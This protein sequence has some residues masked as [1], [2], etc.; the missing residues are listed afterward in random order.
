MLKKNLTS[1]YGKGLGGT[2][3]TRNICKDNESNLQQAD[4]QHQ[5]QWRETQSDFT[6]IR[7]KTSLSTLS[8]AVQYS[9]QSSN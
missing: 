3:D 7:N 6:K 2:R 4:S 5:I 1:L 9:I 8:I